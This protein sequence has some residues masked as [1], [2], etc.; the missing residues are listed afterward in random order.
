[1]DYWFVLRKNA[2]KNGFDEI[3]PWRSRPMRISAVAQSGSRLPRQD[4]IA[5]TG[6]F[7]CYNN[8][9]ITMLQ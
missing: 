9:T 3:I 6:E 8:K 2:H 1:M 7:C 4:L 5:T